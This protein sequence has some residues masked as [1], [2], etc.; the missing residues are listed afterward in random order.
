LSVRPFQAHE[1]VVQNVAAKKGI[2]LK[3]GDNASR[4]ETSPSDV[5]CDHEYGR[6]HHA[7]FESFYQGLSYRSELEFINEAI[8]KNRD[9]GCCI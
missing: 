1:E 8:R 4:V 7:T 2:F 3:V 6:W 5:D 9:V